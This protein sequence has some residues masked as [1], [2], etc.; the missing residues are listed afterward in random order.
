MAVVNQTIF[1]EIVVKSHTVNDAADR[2]RW[3]R[4]IDK[5]NEKAGFVKETNGALIY[6]GKTNPQPTAIQEPP[7]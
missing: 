2:R 7:K 5:E 6:V 1:E 4:E 3:L